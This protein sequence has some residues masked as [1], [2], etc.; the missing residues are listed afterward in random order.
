M[1]PLEREGGGGNN[2][3]G[4]PSVCIALSFSG[5]RPHAR[6]GKGP[7]LGVGARECNQPSFSEA[8]VT[9]W[10]STDIHWDSESMSHTV[11]AVE[12]AAHRD[13]RMFWVRDTS[14]CLASFSLTHFHYTTHTH[15][16]LRRKPTPMSQ[17]GQNPARL[18]CSLTADL[19]HTLKS[20]NGR[21][22]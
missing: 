6:G 5:P 20:A 9:G 19:S 14:V 13:G 17:V 16:C 7:L 22:E 3:P 18:P 4:G 10:S 8:C 15:T 1:K 12:A 11:G 21:T 2:P